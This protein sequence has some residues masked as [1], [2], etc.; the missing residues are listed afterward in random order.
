M[1]AGSTTT[2]GGTAADLDGPWSGRVAPTPS[3]LSTPVITHRV[4]GDGR[5][6]LLDRT[7]IYLWDGSGDPVGHGP[8]PGA[9]AL[10]LTGDG[11]LLVLQDA[12]TTRFGGQ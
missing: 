3:T 4:L 12:A 7:R 9:R 1:S 2:T 11:G 5:V 6:L 10:A 8:V